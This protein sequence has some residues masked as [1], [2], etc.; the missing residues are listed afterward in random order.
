[1]WAVWIQTLGHL[2]DQ[3]APRSDAG[4]SGTMSTV[5][6]ERSVY[7]PHVYVARKAGSAHW[8][9]RLSPTV[10]KTHTTSLR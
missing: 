5:I 7:T 1:M 3:K 2:V 8:V 6:C 9:A 4:L 10:P